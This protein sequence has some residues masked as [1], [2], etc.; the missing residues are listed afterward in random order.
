MRKSKITKN[1]ENCYNSPETFG[2]IVIILIKSRMFPKKDKN[3]D[4]SQM[5]ETDPDTS[6]ELL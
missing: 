6:T 2:K 5:Y 4:D 1:W 3:L